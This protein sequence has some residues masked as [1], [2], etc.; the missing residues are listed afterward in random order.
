MISLLVL[1]ASA[2]CKFVS[3]LRGENTSTHWKATL[4]F[5]FFGLIFF[6]R[7]PLIVWQNS[8]PPW[9][10]RKSNLWLQMPQCF[11]NTGASV[12]P[13]LTLTM[14]LT[15]NKYTNSQKHKYP[16]GY[17]F[18]DCHV[19]AGTTC[20]LGGIFLY[21]PQRAGTINVNWEHGWWKRSW[22]NSLSNDLIIIQKKISGFY[23]EWVFE[24][25]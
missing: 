14:T 21:P 22:N 24:L 5:L 2:E 1:L 16:G 8:H 18:C 6:H 12:A 11:V 23:L 15:S 25:L 13:G 20:H 9:K 10:N 17:I 7:L 19:L 3:H 4:L